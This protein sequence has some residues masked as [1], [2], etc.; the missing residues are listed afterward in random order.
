M[1]SVHNEPQKPLHLNEWLQNKRS[2][3]FESCQKVQGFTQAWIGIISNY[4]QKLTQPSA[5]LQHCTATRNAASLKQVGCGSQQ[6]WAVH[7]GIWVV[8]KVPNKMCLITYGQLICGIVKHTTFNSLAATWQCTVQWILV[9]QLGLPGWLLVRLT[10]TVMTGVWPA[11]QPYER[12][13][14]AWWWFCWRLSASPPSVS[15]TWT[16]KTIQYPIDLIY[17]VYTLL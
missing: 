2:L 6:Q 5:D 7:A 8:G 13:S 4:S 12:C 1:L 3:V 16:D 9:W 10:P 11:P 14:Q 17:N 15:G